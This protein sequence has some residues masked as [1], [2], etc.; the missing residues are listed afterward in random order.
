MPRQKSAQPAYQF[1]VSG[2]ALVRLDYKDF[3]LGQHGTPES[4]A[5]YYSLLAEYNANGRKAPGDP[6]KQVERQ[7]DTTIKVSHV[8]ADFIA[9]VIPSSGSNQNR[10]YQF[11]RL[12]DLLN[13]RFGGDD[14]S[15]EPRGTQLFARMVICGILNK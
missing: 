3:Y 5:R 9:R 7:A 12:C 14:I 2:Q 6:E 15:R 4:Y 13:E 1:H 11:T 10:K 8:T